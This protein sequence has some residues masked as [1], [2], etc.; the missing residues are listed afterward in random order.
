MKPSGLKVA[1]LFPEKRKEL[2]FSKF[3]LESGQLE[4][5][6]YYKALVSNI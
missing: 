5:R 6:E 2:V 3:I 4:L 1:D